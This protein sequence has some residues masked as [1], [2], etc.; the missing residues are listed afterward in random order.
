MAA[1]LVEIWSDV[2]CPWCYIG[3]RKF[4]TALADF[5][6]RADV[7]VVYRAYQLDP[8]APPGDARP[9]P[10]V[11]AKKF[12]G[13]E[14]AAE[15]IDRVT[16]IAAEVGLDFRMDR[17][18]RANTL[19]AHRLLWSTAGT[20]HQAA[21]KERRRGVPVEVEIMVPLVG[22]PE[23][24]AR[25]R[26][27]VER[28]AA[29]VVAEVSAEPL[30]IKIGTMIEV[31]R[32]ALQ[33]GPIAKYA[34]FFSFGTNDLTQMTLGVSRDDAGRFLKQY[35][36]D[37]ILADDPFDTLDTV[38]VGRLMQLAVAEGRQAKPGLKCGIC[39]E[40]GGDP[41]SITF[42]HQIGLDYVSCSP[43]RVPTA[44][45]AAAQ[46]ALAGHEDATR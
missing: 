15:M 11:Y 12:G 4:E 30:A 35:V 31:P 22:F 20:P 46:A 26:A 44:R 28:V 14:R 34:D 16:S 19:D 41:R 27:V 7:E 3:K 23:E 45:L 29:E 6:G 13:P 24:L 21:L 17:A 42:C 39:G 18:L 38:G 10:E 33:A 32:A 2:V 25:V 37:K 43:F 8:T 1:V 40:H 9:V 36:A 5:A